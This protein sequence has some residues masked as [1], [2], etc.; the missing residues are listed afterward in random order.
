MTEYLVHLHVH[1]SALKGRVQLETLPEVL[2]EYED[3][4]ELYCSH[5]R[6]L[7]PLFVTYLP[8]PVSAREIKGRYGGRQKRNS[9]GLISS[10]CIHFTSLRES[11]ELIDNEIYTW[12]LE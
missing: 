8:G 12:K 6:P 11:T 2:P 4:P 1:P 5:T 3:A 9:C 7:V 10:F